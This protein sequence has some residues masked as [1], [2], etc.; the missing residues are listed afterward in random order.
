MPTRNLFCSDGDFSLRSPENGLL[1]EPLARSATGEPPVQHFHR[2]AG[3][4]KF[5]KNYPETWRS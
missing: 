1:R 5:M 3:E 4:R 2:N